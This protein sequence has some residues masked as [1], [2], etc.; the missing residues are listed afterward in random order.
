M[1]SKGS[2]SSERPISAEERKLLDTQSEALR[3][4]GDIAARQ[5]NLSQQDRDYFSQ[6]Y[7]GDLD[8]N[9]PKVKAEVSKRLAETPMPTREQFKSLVTTTSGGLYGSSDETTTR[10]VFDDKA[11]A[12]AK[13]EWENL[14]QNTIDAVSSDLGSKGVDELLF[15]A[16]KESSNQANELLTQWQETASANTDLFKSEFSGL[17][18]GFQDTLAQSKSQIG[19]VNQDVYAQTKGQNLA[20]IS[21]AYAESRKQL[22]GVLSQRGLAGSGI[23]A[24]ALSSNIGA[25]AMQKAGALG[26]SYNQALGISEQQRQQSLGMDQTAYGIGTQTAGQMYDVS[27]NQ[28]GQNVQMASAT[29]QQNIGNLSMASGVSQGVYGGAQNYLGQAGNTITSQASIAGQQAGALGSA[30][31]NYNTGQANAAAAEQAGLYGAI[32][33]G[34]GIYAASGSD[35]RFKNNIKFIEEVNGIKLYTWEWNDFAIDYTD[36]EDLYEPRGV[37][38]QELLL[39]YPELVS[40]DSNGYY[41]VDYDGVSDIIG[42]D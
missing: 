28:A 41:Q 1:G 25:E 24:G 38:A 18:Q 30:Q 21:Q 12:D 23:E 3:E 6:I 8:P 4:A 13:S 10:E 31:A 36:E 34:V 9:D 37:I 15:E 20:G 39:T 22:E 26:Q 27:Q 32:G 40:V 5:F 33:T 17:S 29:Q 14:K 2:S 42:K 7:R 16:V 19:Q 35:F 11:Y